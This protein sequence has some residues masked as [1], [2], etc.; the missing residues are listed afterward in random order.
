MII[1]SHLGIILL[2]ITG[3]VAILGVITIAAIEIRRSEAG[4]SLIVPKTTETPAEKKK[5]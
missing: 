1:S 5:D 2:V 4:K 3:V